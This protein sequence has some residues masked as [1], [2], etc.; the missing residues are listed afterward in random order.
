[1]RSTAGMTTSSSGATN[2]HLEDVIEI[3]LDGYNPLEA[4]AG[5]DVV[6]LRERLGHRLTVCGNSD[7]RVR[8]RGDPDEIRLEVLH[9]LRSAYGGSYIF[10]SDHSVSSDVSGHTY[11][12]IVK[13]VREYG[14]YPLDLP[15]E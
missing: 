14:E 12:L 11:D 7:L 5:L 1:M 3:G 6:E 9:R 13:L 15:E 10:M 4:K 2:S 8:E